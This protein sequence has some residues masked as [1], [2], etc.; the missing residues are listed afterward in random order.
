MTNAQ[1]P[2]TNLKRGRR[3]FISHWD[4]DIGHSPP[5]PVGGWR[6]TFA[7]WLL[8]SGTSVVCQAIGVAV[9]VLSRLVMSPAQNGVWQA[10]KLLLTNGNYANLGVS[11]GAARELTIAVGRGD[12]EGIRPTLNLAFTVNSLTSLAYGLA[13]VAVGLWIGGGDPLGNVWSLGLV[14]VGALSLLQRYLTFQVTLLRSKLEFVSASRLAV[15][16]AALTLLVCIP[17]TWL[18]G[19]PGLYLGTAGVMLASIAFLHV[20]GALRFHWAWDWSEIRR[21]LAIGSPLMLAGLVGT[22]FRS[23]DKLMILA[24]LTDREHQLGCYSLALM[25]TGQLYGLGNMLSIV[26]GPRLGQHF[27]R[28]GDRRALADLTFRS[29]EIQAAAMALPAAWAIVAAGPVLGKMLPDYQ[30]GLAPMFWLIPGAIAMALALPPGQCLTAVDRQ[31]WTLGATL[32]ATAL[33]ALAMHAALRC[34]GGLSGVAIAASASSIAYLTIMAAPVW[35]QLS[36][37]GRIRTL[38]VHVLAVGPVWAAAVALETLHPGRRGAWL[39]AA[40]KLGLVSLVWLAALG[41]GWRWGGWQILLRRAA[42][43]RA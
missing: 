2:M 37:G 10:L 36:M 31:N 30:A 20:R 27:G 28:L 25:V 35:K 13:L 40:V 43:G 19:L 8:V 32:A 29:S 4:L 11:K 6:R 33:G 39:D 5:A 38:A 41:A 12:L 7:D 23:L 3:P 16:E 15:L 1:I 9:S 22:L 18:G 34:G 26:T 42:E 21:L 24:Y 17:A 14:A